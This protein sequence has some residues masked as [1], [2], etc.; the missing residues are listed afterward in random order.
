MSRAGGTLV[1]MLLGCT[2]LR[3]AA[4]A[5][6]PRLDART[7]APTV[8]AK[9]W[10]DFWHAHA[11][12][13][14]PPRDF[15]DTP[16]DPLPQIVNATAGL[17]DDATVKKWILADLRRGRGDGWASSHLRIDVARANL[18][19]PPGLNGTDSGIWQ[20][21]LLGVVEIRCAEPRSV[22]AAAAVV[23]VPGEVQAENSWAG[24]TDYV[25][26][27]RRE[28]NA[29]L[30]ERVFRDGHLETIAPR[31]PPGTS[32]WQLDTGAFRDSPV[33]GPLWYQAHGWSCVPDPA[34]PIGR[35]CGVLP[36]PSKP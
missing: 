15:L 22:I 1:V 19:G 33:I 7:S 36:E 29:G 26:V 16:E 4:P 12:G 21:A 11:V 35:L 5:A 8:G 32:S 25:I 27:L 3:I 6:A 31:Q 24:L 34:T 9:A 30:C 18:F 28:R 17:V 14:S 20:E 23:S 10:D 13:P 2:G